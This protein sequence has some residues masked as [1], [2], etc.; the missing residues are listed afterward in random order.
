MAVRV[1]SIVMTGFIVMVVIGVGLR[2]RS[3]RQPGMTVRTVVMVLVRPTPV[4]VGERAVHDP[5]V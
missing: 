2:H 3:E 1:R 5:S 4:T